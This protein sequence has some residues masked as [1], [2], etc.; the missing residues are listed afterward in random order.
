[1][2]DG[3]GYCVRPILAGFDIP[4]RVPAADLVLF[5]IGN[6]RIRDAFIFAGI[7]DKH[8]MGHNFQSFGFK[9]FDNEQ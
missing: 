8:V 4:G 5:Q 1:L 6:D 9:P 7:T 2:F 3:V